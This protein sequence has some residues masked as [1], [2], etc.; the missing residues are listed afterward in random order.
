M[1]VRDLDFSS[2]TEQ[3]LLVSTGEFPRFSSFLFFTNMGRGI[4]EVLACQIFPICITFDILPNVIGMASLYT[5]YKHAIKAVAIV[6]NSRIRI[7]KSTN[8]VDRYPKWK[9]HYQSTQIHNVRVTATFCLLRAH[10]L[11]GLKSSFTLIIPNI[12]ALSCHAIA[13]RSPRSYTARSIGTS[14]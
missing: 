2:L 1:H 11:T 8:T 3:L 12:T 4:F 10:G 14:C 5:G 7:A 9:H 6:W 13:K